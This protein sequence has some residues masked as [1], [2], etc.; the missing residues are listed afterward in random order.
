VITTDT[1]TT[2]EP[3]N[4][5]LTAETTTTTTTTCANNGGQGPQAAN[6]P[7]KHE[8]TTTSTTSDVTNKPGHEPGGHNPC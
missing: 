1:Q 3:I 7:D 2:A 8:S 4:G 5:G 6:C